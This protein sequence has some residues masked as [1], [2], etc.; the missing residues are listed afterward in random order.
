[1]F[2]VAVDFDLEFGSRRQLQT[3]N[4]NFEQNLRLAIAVSLHPTISREHVLVEATSNPRI[5]KVTIIGF[6]G[7]SIT[8]TSIVA[9]ASD[10]TF[11][12]ELG[13][14]LGGTV[15]MH[16]A[17]AIIMRTTS[18]PSP[19]PASPPQPPSP[20]SPPS[21]P[22]P[23][24]PPVPPSPPV[25][26]AGGANDQS[27]SLS[28]SN[29]DIVPDDGLTQE[30][31]WV[32]IIAVIVL[33][34]LIGCALAFCYGKYSGKEMHT[35][36]IGAR[37]GAPSRPAMRRQISPEEERRR[38]ALSEANLQNMP[39]GDDAVTTARVEDVRLQPWR[40]PQPWRERDL[41]GIGMAVE[42]QMSHRGPS[43]V[44]E[45]LDGLQSAIDEVRERISPRG[46]DFA[47][48]PPDLLETSRIRKSAS[49]E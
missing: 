46:G 32:I 1:M 22:P 24:T 33:I 5:Y 31:L 36:R 43:D 23:K 4:A 11:L 35:I 47:V 15:A 18:V 28:A 34:V 29:Q 19:P 10:A 17:P 37:M 12:A 13:S 3:T 26:L 42:R 48:T 16:R 44:A 30:M 38:A 39:Q 41:I 49:L 7:W 21:P 40:E 14:R 27:S 45:R 8:P 6:A 9:T 25:P 2:S 20:P